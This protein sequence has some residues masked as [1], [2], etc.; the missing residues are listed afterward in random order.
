MAINT[1]AGMG[2]LSADDSLVDA[3][4]SEILALPLERRRLL[5]PAKEVPYLLAQ[6]QLAQ[7]SHPPVSLIKSII[8]PAPK[9]NLR[10]ALDVYQSAVFAEPAHLGLRTRLAEL[11]L[12]LGDAQAALGVVQGIAEEGAS[13]TRALGPLRVGAMGISGNAKS[14]I[15]LAQK[16]IVATP[17]DRRAWEALAYARSLEKSG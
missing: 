11:A 3:A 6:H 7:V 17:W 1:L 4:V 12:Y 8:D 5:D 16:A 10:G 15:A 9:D 13:E 2:I 14:A